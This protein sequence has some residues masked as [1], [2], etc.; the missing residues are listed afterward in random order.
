MD[1]LDKKKFREKRLPVLLSGCSGVKLLGVPALSYKP[2]KKMGPVIAKAT[3]LEDRNCTD[4]VVGMVFDTTASNT[5][6]KTA[7]CVS[8]QNLLNRPLLWLAC[9]HHIGEIILTHEWN[10][11]KIEISKGPNINLFLS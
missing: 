9:R 10:S 8:I 6:A 4:C 7:G 3:L 2:T 1:S 11:L 5:G